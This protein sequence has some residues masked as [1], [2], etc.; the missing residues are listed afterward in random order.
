MEGFGQ[1]EGAVMI[2]NLYGM[3]PK[4]G[5]MGKPTPLYNIGMSM[6]SYRRR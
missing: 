5:S 2:A 6:S 1:T 3:E 4:P